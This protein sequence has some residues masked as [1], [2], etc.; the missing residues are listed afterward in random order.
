MSGLHK[1]Q[2]FSIAS[3]AFFG[4]YIQPAFAYIDPGTGSMVVQVLIGAFVGLGI[5][6]KAYWYKLKE[7]FMRKKE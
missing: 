4:V 7:K 1:Y 3:L 5:A 6:I 2:I